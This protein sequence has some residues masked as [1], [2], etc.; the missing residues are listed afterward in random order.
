MLEGVLTQ[1]GPLAIV[2]VALAAVFVFQVAKT[3][4]ET[5]PPARVHELAEDESRRWSRLLR[6]W[7][8]MPGRVRSAISVGR[9]VGH[10]VII[11]TVVIALADVT[12]DDLT[13][14]AAL[15]VGGLLIMLIVAVELLARAIVSSRAGPFVTERDLVELIS[16]GSKAG[17]LDKAESRM[18]T[19]VIGLG[20]TSVR[21]VMIPRTDIAALPITAT[22]DEVMQAVR[23]Q[24]HTRLPVYD[25][26]L[27]TV[28][29]FFHAKDLLTSI[30]PATFQLKDHIRPIEL[31][32]ESGRVADLLRTFQRKKTHL[33]IVVDDDYGGTSGIVAM[34]DILEEIVGPI[35]DEHDEEEAQIKRLPDGRIAVAGRTNLYDLKDTVSVD[36]PEGAYETIGGF[37]TSVIG[38]IPKN[39]DQVLHGGFAFLITDADQ[40]RVRRIEITRRAAEPP[41]R[42]GSNVSVKPIAV[43]ST[44]PQASTSSKPPSP[45]GA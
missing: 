20:D 5:I 4:L 30:T 18:L 29:G 10:T 3:G 41:Q 23:E 11:L 2:V 25:G 14:A 40:R 8:D 7:R 43:L 22:Y 28:R 42:V 38:R 9:H 15:L 13:P 1:T 44:P 34:E 16:L 32:P 39:G 17:T 37:M 26:T 35:Q 6:A 31:V 45:S 33:A 12:G 36:F 21:E 27:D 19:S 24:G